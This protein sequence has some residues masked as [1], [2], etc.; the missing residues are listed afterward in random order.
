MTLRLAR[1]HRGL[2]K[3]HSVQCSN[4]I[5]QQ[6]TT[7]FDSKSLTLRTQPII[8]FWIT[9]LLFDIL[10]HQNW[11]AFAES[12]W[13]SKLKLDNIILLLT[14][15]SKLNTNDQILGN[16]F[17]NP[18]EIL[19]DFASFLEDVFL[20]SSSVSILPSRLGRWGWWRV[21]CPR[22]LRC[23]PGSLEFL[24]ASSPGQCAWS[25]ESEAQLQ[26]LLLPRGSGLQWFP[27]HC[28]S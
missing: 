22:G 14:M 27:F 2:Y 4:F 25:P 8:H 6:L 23:F 18:S 7:T 16:Y 12:D 17:N 15:K 24:L 11:I 13:I 5:T 21:L 1:L 26:G 3:T 28:H 9:L 20:F 19:A 10:V